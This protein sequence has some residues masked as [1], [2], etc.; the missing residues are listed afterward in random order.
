[1]VVTAYRVQKLLIENELL[2]FTTSHKLSIAKWT[3][4]VTAISTFQPLSVNSQN[5]SLCSLH[6]QKLL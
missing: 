4:Y 3:S 6:F 5:L 1:M 2:D